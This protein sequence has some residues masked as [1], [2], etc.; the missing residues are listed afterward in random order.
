MKKAQAHIQNGQRFGRLNVIDLSDDLIVCC[1]P[2]QV[3]LCSARSLVSGQR[4]LF[5]SVVSH[6]RQRSESSIRGD[7]TAAS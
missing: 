6:Q 4:D 1:F 7:S 2:I 3:K 5:R